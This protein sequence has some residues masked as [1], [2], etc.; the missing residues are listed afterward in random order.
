[1]SDDEISKAAYKKWEAEGRPEGQE[2]R[3]WLEAE[4]E[5]KS[6]DEDPS[7]PAP[8]SSEA[9]PS[10][11]KDGKGFKPGELASENK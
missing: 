3:H 1:M 4:R 5:L 8:T 2:Q 6:A 10:K 7:Q 11:G 9:I